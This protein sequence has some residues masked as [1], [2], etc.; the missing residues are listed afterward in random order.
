MNAESL[1]DIHLDKVLARVAG[2]DAVAPDDQ[3][4]AVQAMVDDRSR[5]LVVQATGWGKSAVYWAA[6]SADNSTNPDNW[7]EI[8]GDALADRL[9]VLLVSPERLANLRF[10]AVLPR[11]VAAAGMVAKTRHHDTH[12]YGLSVKRRRSC[13]DVC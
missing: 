8:L 5:V 9:D 7:D 6:T 1:A 3:R 12:T 2:P 11:L 4:V 13:D 10:S